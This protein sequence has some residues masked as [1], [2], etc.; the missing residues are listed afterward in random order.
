[1]NL[2]K[3][4]KLSNFAVCVFNYIF[5]GKD[6]DCIEFNNTNLHDIV[7][8]IKVGPYSRY[9]AASNFDP[10]KSAELVRGF[11]EG[12]DL[13]Y[14][15][16]QKRKN[17]SSNI[18]IMVGT[19]EEMWSK[20]MKEVKSGRHAGPFKQIPYE[21]YIQS[22]IGLVPKAGNKT[23]LIFHLSYNFNES[24]KSF[25]HYTPPEL[26]TVKYNDLD[27]T[28]KL[29]LLLLERNRD[30]RS[31]NNQKQCKEED[32]LNDGRFR[33]HL[34]EHMATTIFMSKSDLMNAFKILPVL[35]SQRK[36]LIMKCRCPGTN[37]YMFF[38]EKNLPFGS[39]ISCVKFQLFSD[40]L[41]A[42]LEFATSHYQVTCN[43]L[44]DFLFLSTDEDD[45]NAMVRD[46]IN[47]CSEIG[48]P[49]SLDKTEWAS[50]IMIFLEIL[51]NGVT[52]TLSI[53]ENKRNKALE[54]INWAIQRKK[55]TIKF[56]QRLTGTLNFIN[57][58]IVPGQAFT[59]GMYTKLKITN[60]NG[61]LLK[62]HHHVNLNKSFIDNCEIWRIFL[63]NA[64]AR[65]L[66]RPFVDLD[67][68]ASSKTLN[69][70]SDSS[71]N[72]NLGFGT[73]FK[74]SWIMEKWGPQFV[75]EEQPSIEF[76]ELF[77][78][79][80]AILTW[81]H[82]PDLC[83]TRVII[84]CDNQASMHMVNNLASSYSQCMKL[85]RILTLNNLQFNRRVFVKY[86]K[87]ADNVLSDAL[88]RGDMAHFW[89]NAPSNM[90]KFPDQIATQI[91]PIHKIW[92]DM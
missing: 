41:R 77:A 46:F 47:L 5:L 66:C 6:A 49:V 73:V 30:Q 36:F 28:I 7:T 4:A 51:I 91:W 63:L 55:V 13:G 43:Y 71:H 31:D 22:P 26:C 38:I 82:K 61:E 83:N 92:F 84:F 2:C 10:V 39:S 48:C 19:E 18:P 17:E 45:C 58:A 21:S 65:E 40:S 88:S 67:Y 44:D 90:N 34:A 11:K 32:L 53:P 85:I 14:R 35:L 15:G 72:E 20:L 78:L 76:L 89:C 79:V 3:F 64:G 25:N 86:I 68:F 1:M 87:S 23:R 50:N 33:H 42:I 9:L 59:C 57:R 16:P 75:Q 60:E 62:P 12:F 27:Y 37:K 24:E 69:F 70:Y 74:T 81:S 80:A 52:H 56:I 54:L 29:C 8:T